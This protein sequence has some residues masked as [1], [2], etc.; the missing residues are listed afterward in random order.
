MMVWVAS[1]MTAI[2]CF[3]LMFTIYKTYTSDIKMIHT[4]GAQLAGM[5]ANSLVGPLWDINNTQIESTLKSLAGDPDFTSAVVYDA[6]GAVVAS[7]GNVKNIGKDVTFYHDIIYEPEGKK[8]KIGRIKLT[9]TKEN[10]MERERSEIY[11]DVLSFLIMLLATM[12]TVLICLNRI[13]MGPLHSLLEAIEALADGDLKREVPIARQDEFGRVAKSFNKMTQRLRVTY[14]AIQDR[15]KMLEKA[16]QELDTARI[17]ADTA[18]KTKSQ[19]LANMSHELRTPLNAIIGYSEI[20]KEDLA[21]SGQEEYTDDLNKITYAGKHLLEIIS[22]ILDLSKI[23]AG[24]MDVH[25]EEF[26]VLPLIMGIQSV[27]KPMLMKNGNTLKLDC[28]EDIGSMHSDVTKVKQNIFNL[29]SN[30]TKFTDKGN[31]YLKASRH[32]IDDREW[33]EF[34]VRDSGI[35]MTGEQMAN[36]FQSFKQADSSTTKKYG[37]TGLGLAITKKFCQML[38][39]DIVVESSYGEGSTFRITQPAHITKDEIPKEEPQEAGAIASNDEI[40]FAQEKAVS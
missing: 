34:E 18:N 33:I 38:G 10:M 1:V 27:I 36:L 12:A 28:P 24:R 31:V 21:D 4:H 30:A 7:F 35:G 22:D 11:K 8:Q 5:Q 17:E 37:G 40:P 13:I 2:V 25:L 19:F 14:S 6:N 15:S 3:S 20:L 32:T 26:E 16:N 23:E 9:L 29:L 39:G